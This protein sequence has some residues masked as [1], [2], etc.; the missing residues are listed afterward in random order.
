MPTPITLEKFV[1][2]AVCDY[3]SR[4]H[5]FFY[6]SNNAPIFDVRKKV[7]HAMPKYAKKGVADITLIIDGRVWYLECKASNG[8]QSDDQ[9][10]FEKEAVEAGA[11]YYV[12][13]SIDDVRALRL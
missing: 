11:R 8:K 3:L 4:R 1:L 12:I 2:D 9:K 10:I 6:R 5:Y 13:K 7:F